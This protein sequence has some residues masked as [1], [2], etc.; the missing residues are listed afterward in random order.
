MGTYTL[1]EETPPKGYSAIKDGDE[2]GPWT[3]NICYTKDRANV[4]QDTGNKA[5]N[6]LYIE[7]IMP[8]AYGRS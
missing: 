7:K 1:T 5:S 8:K 2:A 3:I 4:E 6:M